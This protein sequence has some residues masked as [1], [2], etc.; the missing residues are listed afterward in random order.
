MIEQ[1][2]DERLKA[3]LFTVIK[4]VTESILE[5]LSAGDLIEKEVAA[6]ELAAKKAAEE[7]QEKREA[8]HSCSSSDNN[9]NHQMRVARR[10]VMQ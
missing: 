3:S 9:Y 6:A 1:T 8:Q 2:K 4:E 7:L 10:S 5:I